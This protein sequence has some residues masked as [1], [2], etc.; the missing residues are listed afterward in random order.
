MADKKKP[1]STDCV[2]AAQGP[3]DVSNAIITPIVNCAPF[4][5]ENTKVLLE[6]LDGRGERTQAEYGRMGNPTVIAVERKLAALEG[7]EQA[8]LFASGMA[9]V[10]TIFLHYLQS[11][12]HLIIT[13]DSYKR[14]RSF[15]QTF[16]T[17]FQIEVSV[18]E[19]NMEAIEA[20]LRPETKLIFTESPSNPYLYVVDVEE[21]AKLGKEKGILTVVDSTF[22]TPLNFRPLDYGID[23]VI[24]SATKY[25]GGHN[26]LIAGV[27]MGS[28]EQVQPVWEFLMTLGGVCDPN[29][30][31]LLDRGLKTLALRVARHNSNATAVAEYLE[32]HPKINKVYYPSLPSHPHHEIATRLMSGFGGVVSFL[33]DADFDGTNRFIDALRIPQ[34]APSLGGAEALV[35]QVVAIGYWC[36]TPEEREAAGVKDNLVRLS[37]G[38]EEPEDLI[39]DLEQALA[40]F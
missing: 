33:I 38:L 28:A 36:A 23:L 31:F 34:I 29:T 11:G 17:K 1:N 30:A 3:I 14:T 15:C 8:L 18:V 5:F 2:H 13:S 9:T 25:L 22:A 20:A 12:D 26:D 4:A 16:L 6:F 32:R 21:L 19:P 39:A 40:S 10:T 27:L 35:E 7:S 37:L 24:H